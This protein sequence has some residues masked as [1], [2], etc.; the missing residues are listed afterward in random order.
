[1]FKNNWAAWKLLFMTL[2]SWTDENECLSWTD[3]KIEVA[4]QEIYFKHGD[5]DKLKRWRKVKQAGTHQKKA[6]RATLISYKA[7]FRTR[8]IIND[9]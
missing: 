2:K 8:K 3:H 1:M 5:S 6:G 7:D 9:T 4:E